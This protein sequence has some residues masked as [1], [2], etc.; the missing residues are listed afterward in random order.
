[1]TWHHTSPAGASL[2]LVVS[3]YTSDLY[4]REAYQLAASCF[5]HGLD[6]LIECVEDQAPPSATAHA[7][8]LAN[9]N[10]K[11]FHLAAVSARYPER[12][13]LWLDA[14]ARVRMQ[15]HSLEG[16]KAVV[17]YVT[18]IRPL[19]QQPNS[20]TVYLGSGPRRDDLLKAWCA[21]VTADRTATDQ[22]CLGRA[23]ARC[24]LQH[25]E[26]P[27]EYCA[28][29]DLDVDGNHLS[30]DPTRPAVI[31]HM[32]ASRITRRAAP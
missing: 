15:P 8:W 25:Y 29:Y 13:L 20:G 19:P 31:Q 14:D 26:L 9:T 12:A 4:K 3:Y 21:E 10:H 30:M 5:D 32:Q 1:M 7:R 2:P 18:R 28:I 17:A 6:Y 16:L 24:G 27:R 11:P 23:V 22:V